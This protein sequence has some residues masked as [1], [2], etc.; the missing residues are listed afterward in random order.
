MKSIATLSFSIWLVSMAIIS[1]AAQPWP[2][3]LDIDGQPLQSGVQYYVLPGITDVAGGLTLV[4]RNKSCPLYVGQEPIQRPMTSQGLPIIFKSF[5]KEET[6]IRESRDLTVTFRAF[7][8]C[9]QSNAWR[10]GEDN[11]ETGRRFIVTGG[12]ADYFAIQSS[13]E[14]VYNFVWCPTNSCPTCDRPRCGSAGIF[15]ENDKR[16][17]VLDGPA[18][19]FR[20][21]R[22]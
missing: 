6:I 4:N 2:A 11:P 10:V 18:F 5:A 16:L 21:S 7:T 12:E 20:F 8:T 9:I 17:L 19:P 14:D 22:V 15:V 13:G 1:A 3:V